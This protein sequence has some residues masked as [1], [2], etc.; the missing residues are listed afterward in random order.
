MKASE[1]SPTKKDK[2]SKNTKHQQ[3]ALNIPV[4]DLT[5]HYFVMRLPHM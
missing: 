4:S 2:H 5:H 1:K 3:R